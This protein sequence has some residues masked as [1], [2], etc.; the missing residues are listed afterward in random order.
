MAPG[1]RR[2]RA[3]ARDATAHRGR[4]P[5]RDPRVTSIS[6]SAAWSG[7]AQALP[8]LV[9]RLVVEAVHRD[10]IG[11]DSMLASQRSGLERHLGALDAQ[12]RVVEHLRALVRPV[13][14]ERPAVGDVQH[15]ETAAHA[16]DRD[17]TA[18]ARVRARAPA[19]IRSRARSGWWVKLLVYRPA[20]GRRVEVGAAGEQQPVRRERSRQPRSPLRDR[21]RSGR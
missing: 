7:R 9:D 11:A 19:S 10:L 2:S 15:L 21:R 14:V 8:D 18:A 4:I 3:S 20:V 16:E 1:V 17:A 13:L 12:V 5:R 6:P